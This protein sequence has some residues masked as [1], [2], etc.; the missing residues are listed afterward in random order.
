[1]LIRIYIL[2]LLASVYVMIRLYSGAVLV[3]LTGI[4]V[5]VL[6]LICSILIVEC[7]SK[8]SVENGFNN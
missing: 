3:F 5:G 6:K 8:V 2:M 1:M 7:I 4:F